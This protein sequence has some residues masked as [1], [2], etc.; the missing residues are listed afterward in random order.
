M[1]KYQKHIIEL[2]KQGAQLHCTEG[3]NYKCWL[4]LADG[5]RVNLRR[6]SAEKICREY[7]DK[8]VFG[9]IKNGIYWRGVKFNN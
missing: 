8:L 3:A 7:Q 2:L 9:D 6:D 4:V 1:S 5:T